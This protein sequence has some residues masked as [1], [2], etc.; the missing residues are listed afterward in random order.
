MKSLPEPKMT[1]K[2]MIEKLKQYDC[3][4]FYIAV[5][6]EDKPLHYDAYTG[7]VM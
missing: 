1:V 6:S 4:Q 2:D 3:S 7:N 5:S